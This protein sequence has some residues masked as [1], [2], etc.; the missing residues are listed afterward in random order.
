MLSLGTKQLHCSFCNSSCCVI[1]APHRAALYCCTVLLSFPFSISCWKS[2][3]WGECS[4]KVKGK[5]ARQ[6]CCTSER[7]YSSPCW[8]W[9]FQSKVW[10][11]FWAASSEWSGQQGF[12][13]LWPGAASYKCEAFHIIYHDVGEENAIEMN[14][15]DYQEIT[16]NIC[17]LKSCTWSF[18]CPPAL[19]MSSFWKQGLLETESLPQ[20]LFI[21]MAFSF[22]SYPLVVSGG[23]CGMKLRMLWNV[24]PQTVCDN[25]PLVSRAQGLVWPWDGLVGSTAA[26]GAEAGAR[27]NL[28]WL[29]HF[30]H[31]VC[32]SVPL[33]LE[34]PGSAGPGC[35]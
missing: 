4:L 11:S 13:V 3:A 22:H 35:L 7:L 28:L 10:N 1:L 34:T 33:N 21:V 19:C 6:C 20:E 27:N 16:K 30:C 17:G 26:S 12:C 8:D 5:R 15:F 29:C 23:I 31:R 32:G 18:S 2:L 25:A 24:R 9:L 14:V